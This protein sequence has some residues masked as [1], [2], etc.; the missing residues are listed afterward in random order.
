MALRSSSEYSK[1]SQRTERIYSVYFFIPLHNNINTSIIEISVVEGLHSECGDVSISIRKF[2]Q[3]ICFVTLRVQAFS[4]SISLPQLF[5]R[6]LREKNLRREERL[7]ICHLWWY[8]YDWLR[9]MVRRLLLWGL[10]GSGYDEWV[11]IAVL[12]NRIVLFCGVD[13]CDSRC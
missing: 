5:S 3:L 9:L 1:K 10:R 11:I 8:V 13:C 7:T 4:C 2:A 6:K 12:L